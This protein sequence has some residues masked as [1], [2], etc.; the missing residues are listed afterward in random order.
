MLRKLCPFTRCSLSTRPT[1]RDSNPVFPSIAKYPLSGN[2]VLNVNTAIEKKTTPP[3]PD[4]KSL[5]R[6]EIR[7]R[8]SL[9]PPD[10]RNKQTKKNP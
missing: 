4:V 5:S 9:A 2:T 7:K 3:I 1:P 6:I 10:S 8:E